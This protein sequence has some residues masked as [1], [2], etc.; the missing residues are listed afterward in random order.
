MLDALGEEFPEV[1]FIYMTGPGDE[2][3][4]GVNRTERNQQIQ[5]VSPIAEDPL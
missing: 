5:R 4:N 3:Y 1:T 2:E